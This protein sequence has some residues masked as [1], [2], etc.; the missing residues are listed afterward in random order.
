MHDTAAI[1]WSGGDAARWRSGSLLSSQKQEPPQQA[2][3]ACRCFM[4]PC[5]R[6]WRHREIAR[7]AFPNPKPQGPKHTSDLGSEEG[8]ARAVN[9]VIQTQHWSTTFPSSPAVDELE[10]EFQMSTFLSTVELTQKEVDW[11]G[12]NR[13][14]PSLSL[15]HVVYLRGLSDEARPCTFDSLRRKLT[16]FKHGTCF[17]FTNQIILDFR[18]PKRETTLHKTGGRHHEGAG[19]RQRISLPFSPCLACP[20][21]RRLDPPSSH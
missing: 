7:R 13:T 20:A 15:P 6:R 4:T 17:S 1:R 11:S 19:Q 9:R 2:S 8:K 10:R 5:R 18:C 16:R 21:S 14:E 3:A 12:L